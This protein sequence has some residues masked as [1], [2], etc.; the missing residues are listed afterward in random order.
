MTSQDSPVPFF[1]ELGLL[2]EWNVGANLDGVVVLVQRLPLGVVLLV[3]LPKQPMTTWH[4][5][6]DT[7]KPLN[8][9][10]ILITRTSENLC[11]RSENVLCP[12]APSY[13]YRVSVPSKSAIT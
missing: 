1:H 11:N 10:K 2:R 12:R 4:P 7:D 9:Y 6:T 3:P 8:T 5:H 13:Q